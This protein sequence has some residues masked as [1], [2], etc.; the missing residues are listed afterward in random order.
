MTSSPHRRDLHSADVPIVG[1]ILKGIRAAA[2]ISQMELALRLG[3]SQR[4]I[5]FVELGRSR[6]S[7]N[8]ILSWCRESSGTADARNAALISAGYSADFLELEDDLSRDSSAFRAVSEMLAAHDPSPGI[9]FDADWMIRGMN[10]GGQW[11]CGIMMAGYLA[12]LRG[13]AGEIDMIASLA[14]CDGLLSKVSN[15]AEVG[16]VL[17]R[18]LRTEEL[19]RP[20]LKS[21]I[22]ELAAS[23]EQRFPQYSPASQRPAAEPHLQLIVDTDFGKMTFLL[24]QT[25]FGLPQ[26]I[27]HSSLRIELW[28][29]VDDATEDLMK[30]SEAERRKSL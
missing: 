10:D 13:S 2:G 9:I 26:N 15:A 8:L 6:P 20:S 23:L 14:H 5:G 19:M 7:R 16:D 17:L 29:P 24:V 3:V 28:F 27:T 1:D 11:L 12:G 30:L 4:H 25:I 18:Q 22:D 21:R